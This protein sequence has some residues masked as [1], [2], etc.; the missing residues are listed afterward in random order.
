MPFWPYISKDLFF[1][2]QAT[3]PL[4]ALAPVVVAAADVSLW[5][6][7]LAAAPAIAVWWGTRLAL[8]N[9]ALAQRLQGSLDQEKEL[10][11]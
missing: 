6:V 5:L 11:R 1:Q 2:A 7:P 9:A 3:L 10:N 4:V 8:E